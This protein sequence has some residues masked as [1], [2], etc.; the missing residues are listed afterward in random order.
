MSKAQEKSVFYITTENAGLQ[1][2][3][4]FINNYGLL[5]V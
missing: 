5:L 1:W 3:F 4:W 2:K